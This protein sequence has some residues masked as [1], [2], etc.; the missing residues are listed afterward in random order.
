MIVLGLPGHRHLWVESGPAGPKGLLMRN[1]SD[2]PMS[3]PCHVMCHKCFAALQLRRSTSPRHVLGCVTNIAGSSELR[4]TSELVV[5]CLLGIGLHGC[6]V[7]D[8]I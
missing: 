3:A 8:S 6:A 1:P 4:H 5:D 2:L 7:L